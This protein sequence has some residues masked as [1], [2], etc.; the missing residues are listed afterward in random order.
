M[1]R[2]IT[3]SIL[4]VIMFILCISPVFAVSDSAA[5]MVD[6]A[7]LLSASE[8]EALTEKLSEISENQN[9]D[10]VIVTVDRLEGK[11]SQDYADDY[12][13]EN[14]Y[15]DDGILLLVSMEDRD[16]AISTKGYGI[17]A[18]TDAGL[19]YIVDEFISDLSDG[20]YADAFQTF[21]KCCDKFIT[22]AKKGEPYDT[23]NMPHSLL[24]IIWIPISFA[25]GLIVAIIVVGI[26]ISK[27][28]TV[29]MQPAA[30]SYFKDGS[31]NI[32]ENRDLFLYNTVS[33]REKPKNNSNGSGSSTHKSSSGATHGGTSGKF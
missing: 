4:A 31:L 26:M 2:K 14:G 25:I 12:Y 28:K 5:L 8:K 23:G 29:R 33:R 21:A 7:E 19:E 32:T 13:D 20:D 11:T 17:I 1:I 16:Y 15:A 30:S 10:V 22:Q 18:F 27:L 3:T 6:N 9:M 24:S